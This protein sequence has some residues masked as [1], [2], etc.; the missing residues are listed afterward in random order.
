MV[1][2]VGRQG[3]N[4]WTPANTSTGGHF[5]GRAVQPTVEEEQRRSRGRVGGEVV[6]E[7]RKRRKSSGGGEEE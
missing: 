6:E 7:E 5:E 3:I 2:C 1:Q 4:Q